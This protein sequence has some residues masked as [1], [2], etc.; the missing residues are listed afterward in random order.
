MVALPIC[1]GDNPDSAKIAVA[2]STSRTLLLIFDAEALPRA[3]A[4]RNDVRRTI[5]LDI[6]FDLV[7]VSQFL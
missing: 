5:V 4:I 1:L 2:G 7:T 3:S 6:L